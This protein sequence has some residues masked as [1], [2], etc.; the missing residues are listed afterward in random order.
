LVSF[1]HPLDPFFSLIFRQTICFLAWLK[2]TR[3]VKGIRRASI[4][5]A[6]ADDDDDDDDDDEVLVDSDNDDILTQHQF[7]VAAK[8]NGPAPPPLS[9]V[10]APSSVL[11]NWEREFEKFAPHMNV[12]K[13]HGSIA[14]REEIQE[15]LRR[16]LLMKGYRR[17]AA[18]FVKR[19]KDSD[20]DASDDDDQDE[21]GVG[22]NVMD[23]HDGPMSVDVILAP[24]TYFQQEKSTDRVFLR[25]LR[26]E[27]LVVDVRMDD[28]VDMIQ[29]CHG[30]SLIH[31]SI[32]FI[33]YVLG[34]SF[35]KECSWFTLQESRPV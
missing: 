25:K 26:Y 33:L 5:A 24:V 17:Q 19:K 20:L 7:T 29:T 3:Q 23:E 4:A 8:S 6:A 18:S 27:Y 1:A 22:D 13:Y 16:R 35:A 11:S 34:G 2:H 21:G 14:E 15:D 10:V 12:V 28:G 31:R 30:V 32:L 9:L